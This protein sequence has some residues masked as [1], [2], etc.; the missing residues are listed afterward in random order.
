[1]A[2]KKREFWVPVDCPF[3]KQLFF[4]G[5]SLGLQKAVFWDSFFQPSQHLCYLQYQ[6][7]FLKA[8]PIDFFIKNNGFALPPNYSWQ[9]PASLVQQTNLFIFW[10]GDRHKEQ[11]DGLIQDNGVMLRLK[12]QDFPFVSGQLVRLSR[13]EKGAT[14]NTE[15]LFLE[16]KIQAEGHFSQQKILKLVLQS[17]EDT[18]LDFQLQKMLDSLEKAQLRPFFLSLLPLRSKKKPRQQE[19]PAANQVHANATAPAKAFAREVWLVQTAKTNAWLDRFFFTAPVDFS[20]AT[21]DFRF[22]AET[23]LRDL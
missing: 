3:C 6:E 14:V 12:K 15:K 20:F 19:A 5:K 4:L 2:E 9:E 13:L 18:I 17:D 7:E 11:Q 1:M 22:T 21:G 8:R 16:E 23:R 10:K